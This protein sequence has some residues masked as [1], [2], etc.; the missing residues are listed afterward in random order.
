MPYY[1]R[2]PKRDHNF[3]NHLYLFAGLGFRDILETTIVSIS[4]FIST[5]PRKLGFYLLFNVHVGLIP[6]ILVS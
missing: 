3:E 4:D 5:I 1:N 2:D 6:T